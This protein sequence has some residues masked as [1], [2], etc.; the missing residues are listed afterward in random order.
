[1]SFYLSCNMHQQCF[2]YI[3]NLERFLVPTAVLLKI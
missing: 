1:M 2:I 3:I